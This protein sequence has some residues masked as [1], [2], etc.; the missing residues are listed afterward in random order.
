MSR[1]VTWSRAGLIGGTAV[2]LFSSIGPALADSDDWQRQEWREHQWREH[3]RAEQEWRERENEWRED[4]P[5]ALAP[6]YGYV[7][8]YYY[9]PPPVTYPPP[10]PPVYVQPA[11]YL[12]FGVNFR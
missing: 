10:P 4:H 5:Y 12:N 11:P 9:A 6:R 1:F 3:E 7:Q 8:R 2:A